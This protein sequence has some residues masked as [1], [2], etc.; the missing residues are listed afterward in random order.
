MTEIRIPMHD[1]DADRWVNGEISNEEWKVL[2]LAKHRAVQEQ[3]E[4]VRAQAAPTRGGA[5]AAPATR[6]RWIRWFR[7]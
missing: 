7:R 6:R 5:E 4:A 3:V 1:P 2:V